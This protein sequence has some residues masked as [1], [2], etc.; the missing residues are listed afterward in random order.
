[1]TS[2]SISPS[3][4]V[5][6]PKKQSSIVVEPLGSWTSA[7]PPPVGPVSG[8]SVTKAA[9]AAPSRASTAFPPSRRTR[10]PASAVSG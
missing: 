4:V 6:T 8:P 7:K 9:N 2:S 10:A 5:G 1:M 3:L